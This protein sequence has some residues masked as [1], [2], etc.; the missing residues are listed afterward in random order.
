MNAPSILEEFGRQGVQVF[1]EGDRLRYRTSRRR[2][3]PTILESLSRHKEELRAL[4]KA[5]QA[6]EHNGLVEPGMGTPV[7]D[8][9]RKDRKPF[10]LLVNDRATLNAV[11]AAIEETVVVGLDLETTGL[12]PRRDRTRLLSLSLDTVDGG[13]FSYLIDCFRIEPGPLFEPLAVKPLVIHNSAFDLAFLHR[14]GFTPGAMVHDTMLLAQ[15]LSAGTHDRH[16]LAAC[17]ERYLKRPLDKVEQQSD[18]SGSLTQDQL[19]YAATDVDVLAP[20]LKVLTAEIQ[21]AGLAYAAD[22]EQRC[23]LALVWLARSGVTFDREAWLTLAHGA[24][25]EAKALEKQLDCTAPQRPGFLTGGSWDWNSAADIKEVLTVVGCAVD[26]TGDDILAALDHPLPALLRKYRSAQKR[27]TTYGDSW[28]RHVEA[29]SRVYPQWW[30]LGAA[31]GRMACSR[32]NLQQVPR[33]VAYRD[34]IQAPA[35]RVLV[36]ADYSQIE[37]RIAAKVSGDRALLEAYQARLDLHVLTAQ[38]V[39]G[40]AKVTKEHRQLA[41]AVNFGLLYG[42]GPTGFQKYARAQYGLML[43]LDQAQAYRSAFFRAYPGLA[44]WHIR[45]KR[46]AATETRTLSGRRCFLSDRSRTSDR[47]NTPV[48]GTGADGLKLA[49]A[50]LWERR[51]QVP[52]AF[53]VLAVHDEVVVEAD[54]SQKDAVAEWLKA[55]MVEAMAPLVEPVPVEV[56]VSI[57]RTWG[58]SA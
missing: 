16:T 8:D 17:C 10:Y 41:K 52:G 11:A 24:E 2:L 47:L 28:V 39:L 18:W 58:G 35:G 44:A 46:T 45:V 57:A 19:I 4:L 31:S 13:R 38:H 20:L 53:P 9:E 15:V 49:L 51:D 34:C 42:M 37:L 22:I 56:E 23:L 54:A 32:P 1:L 30:Q 14:L 50:L 43:S 25:L 36:K 26:S 6:C 5:P 12:N 21:A 55:A 48:Q 7:D 27:V 40:V 29:D 33:A 3:T